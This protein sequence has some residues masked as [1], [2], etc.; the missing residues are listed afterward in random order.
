MMTSSNTLFLSLFTEFGRPMMNSANKPMVR[1]DECGK[2]LADSSSL[3][4]HEKTHGNDDSKG[5]MCPMSD[6]ERKF[7]QR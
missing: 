4:R 2:V 7:I 5:H 3:Y 6:C 1:C